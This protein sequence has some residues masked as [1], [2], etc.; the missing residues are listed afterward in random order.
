MLLFCL[1]F[2][3]FKVLNNKFCLFSNRYC[4]WY[5]FE[6]IHKDIKDIVQQEL[7]LI[8]AAWGV[9]DFRNFE[10]VYL[11]NSLSSELE[12]SFIPRKTS[13][14]YI[15]LS[16]FKRKMAFSAIYKPKRAQNRP[17]FLRFHLF[18]AVLRAYLASVI[19][20]TTTPGPG[21]P[22]ANSW[23]TKKFWSGPRGL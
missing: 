16:T 8:R 5:I 4:G 20:S 7:T 17:F 10:E 3:V 9:Y 12:N 22:P 21:T 11:C 2:D 19:P 1:L 14:E 13:R 23:R 15:L 18:R 6:N